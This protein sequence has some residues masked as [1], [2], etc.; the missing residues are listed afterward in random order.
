MA[1]LW[2]N[3]AY[4][5]RPGQRVTLACLERPVARFLAQR[6]KKGKEAVRAE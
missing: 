5:E 3:S 1:G 2:P 4:R 6:P